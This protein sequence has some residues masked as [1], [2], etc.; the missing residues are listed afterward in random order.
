MDVSE[1]EIIEDIASYDLRAI[2]IKEQELR[3]TYGTRSE[4][5]IKGLLSKQA[6]HYLGKYKFSRFLTFLLEKINLHEKE[7]KKGVSLI[8]HSKLSTD[9]ALPLSRFHGNQT[10]PTKSHLLT[11][12][13]REMKK[14]DIE[15]LL[16]WPIGVP[17]VREVDKSRFVCVV[18]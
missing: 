16:S 12:E 7:E 3:S 2:G 13:P 17:V 15:G 6:Q 9:Q 14:V 1:R 18:G 4:D 8:T 10:A 11:S 5:I